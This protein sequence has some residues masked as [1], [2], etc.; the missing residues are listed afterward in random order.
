MPS[1]CRVRLPSWPP[2]DFQP[3]RRRGGRSPLSVSTRQPMGCRTSGN[4]PPLLGW[5]EQRHPCP[6]RAADSDRPDHGEGHALGCGL[7]VQPPVDGSVCQKGTATELKSRPNAERK[8][9]SRLLFH[10]HMPQTTVPIG[11]FNVVIDDFSIQSHA[12][13]AVTKLRALEMNRHN[14]KDVS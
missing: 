6:G 11:I 8:C 9:A 7:W 3:D 1:Y 14:K 4:A 10:G 5:D 13:A 12:I 2:A